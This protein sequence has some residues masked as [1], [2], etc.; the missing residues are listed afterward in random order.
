MS[1][2]F[3]FER[4]AESVSF[5]SWC[6]AEETITFPQERNKEDKEITNKVP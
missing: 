3:T 5:Y 2:L 1:D 4:F 6:M